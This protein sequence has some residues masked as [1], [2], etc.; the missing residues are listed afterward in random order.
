MI[1]KLSC[2]RCVVV[3]QMKTYV[4]N[5]A[6][7]QLIECLDTVSNPL[8]LCAVSTDRDSCVL[9]TLFSER[10]HVRI[11]DYNKD[12]C[13]EV[14]I[15][16]HD[17]PIGSMTMSRDGRVLATAVEKGMFIRIWDIQSFR[18]L[19]VLKR[20]EQSI[21]CDLTF[22]SFSKSDNGQ[23]IVCS[24]EQEV[25]VYDILTRNHRM[26]EDGSSLMQVFNKKKQTLY[27]CK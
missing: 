4:Y 13:G 25:L 5:L 6:D 21:I 7:M 11:R 2:F 15:P 23:L 17:G 1:C 9:A 24:E 14:T 12:E 8:G 27:Q 19:Q 10:G 3:L 18:P 26:E 20:D 16:C 22:G